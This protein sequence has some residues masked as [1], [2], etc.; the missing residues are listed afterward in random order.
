[1]KKFVGVLFVGLLS[2]LLFT[3]MASAAGMAEVNLCTDG[4]LD[5]FRVGGYAL[6]AVKIIVPLLIIIFGMIDFTKAI[7]ASNDDQIKKSTTSLVKRGIAGV[8]IFFIPTLINTAFDMMYEHTDT[9]LSKYQTCW[10]C[11]LDVSSCPK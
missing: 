1:M 10:D 6:I 5:A 8:I 11:L 3:P 2:F 9:N 4:V 7:L